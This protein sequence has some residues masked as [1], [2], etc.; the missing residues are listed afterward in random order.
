MGLPIDKPCT[1]FLYQG[2]KLEN[3]TPKNCLTKIQ[4]QTNLQ[5]I[6]LKKN[7]NSIGGYTNSPSNIHHKGNRLGNGGFVYLNMYTYKILH[8]SCI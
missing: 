1:A 6:A 5:F 3:M 8:H 4:L 7:I 2:T